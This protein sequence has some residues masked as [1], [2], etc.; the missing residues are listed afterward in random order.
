VMRVGQLNERK[1]KEKKT[2]VKISDLKIHF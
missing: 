1:R 2:W